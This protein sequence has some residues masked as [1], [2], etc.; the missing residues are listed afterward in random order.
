LIFGYLTAAPF[1]GEGWIDG[2]NS[3]DIIGG[4][5][6]VGLICIFGG[7]L[8]GMDHQPFG[9]GWVVPFIGKREAF[10]LSYSLGRLRA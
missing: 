6:L 7:H 10:Y 9:A 1:G 2:V 3:G 8:S 4:P 5:H